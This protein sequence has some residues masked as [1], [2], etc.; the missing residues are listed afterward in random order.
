MIFTNHT[1]FSDLIQMN[2]WLIKVDP[3]STHVSSISQWN[4]LKLKLWFGEKGIL[5]SF[6]THSSGSSR[7]HSSHFVQVGCREV[8]RREEL[9]RP[10]LT[11]LIGRLPHVRKCSHLGIIYQLQATGDHWSTNQ[12]L[13]LSAA[14]Q[15]MSPVASN[16]VRIRED[17]TDMW[18]QTRSYPDL[19]PSTWHL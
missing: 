8:I 19:H 15:M 6:K 13:T 3:M 10:S 16:R 4:S 17:R 11:S 1:L 2:F 14:A 12:S 9:Q 18:D 5:M 7:I